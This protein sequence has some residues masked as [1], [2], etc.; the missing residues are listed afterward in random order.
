MG[1]RA[2]GRSEAGEL[3]PLD[4]PLV[5]LLQDALAIADGDEPPRDRG[6][7]LGLH[8]RGVSLE[9]RLRVVC[10][11]L[12]CAAMS[13]GGLKEPR[14]SDLRNKIISGF[15]KCLTVRHE[16]VV[17][18]S[19]DALAYVIAQQKLQKELLH[20]THSESFLVLAS[21]LRWFFMYILFDGLLSE[22]PT[23]GF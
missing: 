23:S 5:H 9:V 11:E 6:R 13:T 21:T 3:L 14:H 8:M 18:V 22:E 10:I 12:L 4:E 20:E 1:G 7:M 16:E 17:E 19:R 2:R 15:F